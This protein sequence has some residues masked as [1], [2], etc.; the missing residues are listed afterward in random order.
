MIVLTWCYDAVIHDL[1]PRPRSSLPQG[2][3][4]CT[5][6][7]DMCSLGAPGMDGGGHLMVDKVNLRLAVVGHLYSHE[8]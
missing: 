4:Q 7:G 5:A 2:F 3:G 1:D 6:F 8:Y